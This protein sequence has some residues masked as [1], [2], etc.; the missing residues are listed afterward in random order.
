MHLVDVPHL[1]HILDLHFYCLGPDVRDFREC[2]AVPSHCM[3]Y[4]DITR[5]ILPA[6]NNGAF[7]KFWKL[8]WVFWFLLCALRVNLALDETLLP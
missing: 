5:E 6:I 3:E 2:P 8:S 1:C 4:V 7:H